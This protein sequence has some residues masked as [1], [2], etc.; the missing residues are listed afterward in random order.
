[1][2]TPAEIFAELSK[3]FEVIRKAFIPWREQ[4]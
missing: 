2:I 3:T 1:M 4:N